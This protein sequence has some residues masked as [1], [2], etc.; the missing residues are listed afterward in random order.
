M[1]DN[2]SLTAQLLVPYEWPSMGNGVLPNLD[3]LCSRQ[4]IYR[5]RALPLLALLFIESCQIVHR[6]ERVRMILAQYGL[7]LFQILSV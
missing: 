4:F 5:R 6:N 2:D 7:P 3:V 1:D